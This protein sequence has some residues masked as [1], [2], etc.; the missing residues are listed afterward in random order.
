[1]HT[2]RPSPILPPRF[3]TNQYPP[4]LFSHGISRTRKDNTP[5]WIN[6]QVKPDAYTEYIFKMYCSYKTSVE[7]S[8]VYYNTEKYSRNFKCLFTFT[9][10]IL[11]VQSTHFL[12]MPLDIKNGILSINLYFGKSDEDEL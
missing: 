10:N 5:A 2:Y 7:F 1:M 11:S 4:T 9:T 6:R 12:P 3:E 8:N